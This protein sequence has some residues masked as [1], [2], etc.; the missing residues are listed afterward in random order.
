MCSFEKSVDKIMQK[1]LQDIEEDYR[2][3]C[4]LAKKLGLSE[5]NIPDALEF[6]RLYTKLK[7]EKVII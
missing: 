6:A 7:E 1:Q 3:L 5:N 2:H 4:E